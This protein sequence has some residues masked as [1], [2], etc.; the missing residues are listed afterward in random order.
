[1]IN[2][3]QS[4][5]TLLEVLMA[6]SITALIGIG[7]SQL[8]S[9]TAE[10]KKVTDIRAEQLKSIQ[11][12]DFWL[13]RDLW[14][15]AGR[16]TRNQFG[17]LTSIVTSEEDY[18][19]ELTHSGWAA[20]FPTKDPA[21]ELK[22]SNLQRVAYAVRNHNSDDCRDA[23]KQQDDSESGHCFVRYYWPVLDLSANS[24]PTTQVLLSDVDEVRFYFRGQLIDQ[25]NPSN[26][27]VINEWQDVWPSPYANNNLLEDLAQIKVNITTKQLGEIE[28]WY[29]VPRYA[30]T[31]P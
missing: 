25:S 5:F 11:R 22:R 23:I 12:M 31:Q 19:I 26:T 28:R 9:S 10:T 13:K 15:V 1:M 24:E 21:S 29:E 27:I 17:D 30:F 7:A 16:Q 14:Q 20:A 6:V 8:L 2:Q 3:K 4:G 18:A